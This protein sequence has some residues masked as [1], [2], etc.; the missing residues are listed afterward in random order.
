MVKSDTCADS[1]K[2]DTPVT[3]VIAQRC[4]NNLL[5]SKTF[6]CCTGAAAETTEGVA[7]PGHKAQH[8]QASTPPVCRA[9]LA[10]KSTKQQ[11][12]HTALSEQ[13]AMHTDQGLS[14]VHIP[15]SLLFK[16][17]YKPAESV[18]SSFIK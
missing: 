3:A 8:A 15:T 9:V 18:L 4:P 10:L 12:C 13:T 14:N 6:S 2:S 17:T 11:L 1:M 16:S 7:K 5:S